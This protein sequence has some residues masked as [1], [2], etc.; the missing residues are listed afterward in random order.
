MNFTDLFIRRPVLAAVVSLLIFLAGLGAFHELPVRQF[1]KVDNTVITVTT[2][3]PG[4]TS[5]LMRSFITSPIEQA[6]STADGI[7][8]LTSSSFT[9]R[10]IVTAHIKLNFD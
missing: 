9:G 8:Y 4:A 10:S 7:D 5:E 6:V 1:P 3:Y 2:V